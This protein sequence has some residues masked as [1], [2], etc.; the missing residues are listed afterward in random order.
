MRWWLAKVWVATPVPGRL[1]RE[2]ESRLF[3]L[4]KLE[5]LFAGERKPGSLGVFT[6]GRNGRIPGLYSPEIGKHRIRCLDSSTTTTA[7]FSS[8]AV[9][10]SS[11]TDNR[12]IT[13]SLQ[14]LRSLNTTTLT[15]R[16]LA[17]AAISPKSR[18]KSESLDFQQRLCRRSCRCA[19]AATLGQ[20]DGLRH[21]HGS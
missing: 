16:P 10:S 18:S 17:R 19:I 4:P 5:M 2:E 7:P 11:T 12:R 1:T 9:D 20:S 21:V 3:P 15:R 14:V 8:A 13:C 6:E